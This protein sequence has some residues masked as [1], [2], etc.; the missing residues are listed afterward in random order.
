MVVMKE[1]SWLKDA[2]KSKQVMCTAKEGEKMALGWFVQ[3]F[4]GRSWSKILSY[5]D[6]N[7]SG[8]IALN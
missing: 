5:D 7:C 2:A 8:Q 4:H 3:P 6:E 1:T